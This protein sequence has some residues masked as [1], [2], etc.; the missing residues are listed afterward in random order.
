MASGEGVTVVVTI[1]GAGRCYGFCSSHWFGRGLIMVVKDRPDSRPSDC[2]AY[3]RTANPQ[4][5]L[6]AMNFANG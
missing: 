1:G 4:P 2:R 6:Q 3:W 5:A